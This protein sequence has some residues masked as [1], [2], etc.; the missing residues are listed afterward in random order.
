MFTP[1]KWFEI[2]QR[3]FTRFRYPVSMPEDIAHALGI[4]LSNSLPFK[5]C[6]LKI[7]QPGLSPTR[8]IKYMPRELAERAFGNAVRKE[9]FREKTLVSY[10][11]N[12]GWL[13]FVLHF[14]RESRLRRIYIV[15]RDI[16]D[17]RGFELP[18]ITS[19]APYLQ[20]DSYKNHLI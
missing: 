2:L 18:L 9:K 16:Q 17:D 10:Y 13:E 19:Y 15:H 6:M 4:S 1:T 12:E 8:L 3:I 14:D 20:P 11:F 5:E 7:C